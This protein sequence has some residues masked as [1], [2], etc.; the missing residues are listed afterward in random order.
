ML[1]ARKLKEGVTIDKVL[2]DIR[3]QVGT[4]IKRQHLIN[5]QDVNNIKRQFNID[6]IERHKED[7]MSVFAKLQTLDYNP[8][9]AFKPQ[10]KE[11][12]D[13][14]AKD[15]F[16]LAIQTQFQCDLMKTFGT[17]LICMDATHGTNHYHFKLVTVLI[18]DEFGEG[19]PVGW[20]VSNKEDGILLSTFLTSLMDRTGPI[21]AQYFMSD[22]AE[23]YYSSWNKV[24]GGQPRKLLCSWHVD[25][26]WRSQLQSISSSDKKTKLYCSLRTILQT[27]SIPEFRKLMQQSISWML[28]DPDLEAFGHYFQTYYAK[29]NEEW[30]YCYRVGTPVN[31]N[32]SVE[33]FHRLLKVVYLEG[34]HNRRVDHLLSLLL[35]IARDKLFDR[36]IKLEK[37]K[38]THRG[39]EINRR[40][41]A[42]I[43][44]IDTTISVVQIEES[45]RQISSA[46]RDHVQYLVRRQNAQCECKV[47]CGSCG[48]CAHMYTCSC[49][50]SAVH[51]TACKHTHVIHMKY[52]KEMQTLNQSSKTAATDSPATCSESAAE[53]ILA[54]RHLSKTLQ[55]E[56]MRDDG[57]LALD[58]LQDQFQGLVS[59]AQSLAYAST[60]CD[61]LK[62]GISKVQWV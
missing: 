55:D 12:I 51:S 16:L 62:A 20:M 44:M 21:T 47:I 32:M 22:D 37:G 13:N 15:D 52:N 54:L 24:Y 1:V 29:R 9:T 36:L 7:Q 48:I 10:G 23:Q 17:R 34:K 28:S 19:V 41:R 49:V 27:L 5:R 30:A 2:D 39:G 18:L 26:A 25:K 58:K 43:E 35:R 53:E 40:H 56:P 60:D 33:A 11:S 45:L 57:K 42:A 8:V 59:Q 3:D 38:S 14:L 4:S 61:V 6:G 31:T 46:S 50:D